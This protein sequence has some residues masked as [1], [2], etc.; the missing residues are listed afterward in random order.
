MTRSPPRIRGNQCGFFTMVI[1]K[2]KPMVLGYQSCGLALNNTFNWHFNTFNTFK[3]GADRCDNQHNTLPGKKNRGFSLSTRNCQSPGCI[4]WA[5]VA[6]KI[7]GIKWS[8]L[9]SPCLVLGHLMIHF[10]LPIFNPICCWLNAISLLVQSWF[11]PLPG[12]GNPTRWSTPHFCWL[13]GSKWPW[14][15]LKI[16]HAGYPQIQRFIAFP[17]KRARTRREIHQPRRGTVCSGTDTAGPLL[18]ALLDWSLGA[19]ISF[20]SCGKN[21]AIKMAG[22]WSRQGVL[23]NF[24]ALWHCNSNIRKPKSMPKSMHHKKYGASLNTSPA[25]LDLTD[26][27]IPP[28]PRADSF[29][30]QLAGSN[31]GGC[32]DSLG[33]KFET[34][35]PTGFGNF[36]PITCGIWGYSM[37]Y[38][39]IWYICIYIYMYI[40]ICI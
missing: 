35:H 28:G 12:L 36:Y 7:L 11:N 31:A 13:K 1:L 23:R 22:D 18:R 26:G 17:M 30:L 2:G 9:A 4:T 14:L 38:I 34:K 25:W 16:G 24:A 40:N 19:F 8:Y 39:Y 6:V 15:C 5:P 27:L 29:G 20:M 33:A 10:I 37:S 32:H 21:H 3:T